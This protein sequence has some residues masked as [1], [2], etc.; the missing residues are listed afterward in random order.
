MIVGVMHMPISFG[1]IRR[2]VP[3]R[4]RRRLVAV[5]V[6]ILLHGFFVAGEFGIVAVDRNK[7]EQL[8]SQGDRRA[9]SA[10]AALK[11][12]SFQLSGAQLGITITSLLVGFLIEP[13]VGRALEPLMQTAGLPPRRRLSISV[14]LG[15]ILATA[16]EMVVAELI[17]KNLAIARPEKVTFALATPIRMI[18]AVMKPFILFFNAAANWTVRLIGIEPIDELSG[19]KSLEELQVLIRSSRE[20]GAIEEEQFSLLARSITFGDK[21]CADAFTPRVSL[22]TLARDDAVEDLQR[23]LWTPD[24]PVSPSPGTA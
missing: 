16:F 11:T 21:V 24:T 12:L 6:L 9:K 23:P 13:A 8:A 10:L 15:L 19:T 2:E 18:N 4:R 7:V 20:G 1:R 17:P 14:G 22:V 5:L 3:D